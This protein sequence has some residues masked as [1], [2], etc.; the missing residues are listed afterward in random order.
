MIYNFE[1]NVKSEKT[2]SP[3]RNNDCIIYNNFPLKTLN[4][5]VNKIQFLIIWKTAEHQGQKK[6]EYII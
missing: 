1:S 5:A 4:N 2:G 3:S 6:R